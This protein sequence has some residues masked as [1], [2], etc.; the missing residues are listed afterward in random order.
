LLLIIAKYKFQ[1]AVLLFPDNKP[2][3][4]NVPNQ[5]Q[6]SPHFNADT[7]R[8]QALQKESSQLPEEKLLNELRKENAELRRVQAVLEKSLEQFIQI[9]NSAPVGYFT[10]NDKGIIDAVNLTGASMLGFER[11][12]LLRKYLSRFISPEDRNNWLQ[13]FANS[14]ESN[15]KLER[16]FT[17][18]KNDGA[19]LYVLLQSSCVTNDMNES[20]C[21]IVLTDISK[22]KHAEHALHDQE[23]FFNMIAENSD[24]FVSV[25]D[26]KGRR[27][28]NSQSYG[29]L[30]GNLDTLVG[31]DSFEEIHP[32]DRK[33]LQQVFN[34]TVQT[35]H[36]MHADFR[37]ILPDGSVRYMESRGTLVRNSN[38]IALRVV[39]VSRDIT[40]R[41]QA[42]EKISNLALYDT[43]TGKS[44]RRLLHDRLVHVIT[45]NKRRGN[46]GALL[47]ID[48]DNFR[49]FNEQFGKTT[50]DSL[51]VEVASR[52]SNCVR[53]VDSIS[54]LGGDEFAVMLGELNAD[55]IASTN[56]AGVV[57]EKIRNA[58]AEPYLLTVVN[59]G[60]ESAG[61]KYYCTASIG[62]F[63]FSYTDG[64]AD[65]ILKRADMAMYQA[66]NKGKNLICF[67]DSNS[68]QGYQ[69]LITKSGN[70]LI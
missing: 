22:R 36:G 28:Y 63:L 70:S 44:N 46:F 69:A 66:K 1:G 8:A 45:E 35:G 47:F 41:I 27:L 31:T 52:I 61:K 4:S 5:G 67:F 33:Y 30:F 20:E 21:H 43:L 50:G 57:A 29:K 49:V 60:S 64:G 25:L 62:V 15:S 58:L 17:F 34:E 3:N 65:D 14:Q 18:V 51:L 7:L 42:A 10:L 12:K 55:K 13:F 38:G 6:L 16:E 2:T 11:D 40:E 48:L 32:E 24:E 39:V 9:F 19:N 53:E 54:R 26:L 68:I 23:L 37:F 56:Q 59:E